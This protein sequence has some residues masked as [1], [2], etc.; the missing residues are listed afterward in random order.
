LHRNILS[1]ASHSAQLRVN[2]GKTVINRT[3]K[4]EEDFVMKKMLKVLSLVL[5]FSLFAAMALTGCGQAAAPAET[6]AAATTAAVAETTAA[7]E[8]APPGPDISK[9]VKIYGYLLG[10]ALTGFPDV[11][12]ALNEKLK[13]DVNATMEINYIGWADLQAKYPLIL[14]AGENVDWIYTAAWCQMPQQAAKGAFMEMTPDIYQKY[15]PQKWA[16]IKDTT[17]LKEVSV[18]GK[19]YMIPTSTPDRKV[20]V[21]LYRE[22]LRKKYNVPEIKKMTDIEPYLEAIKKNEP[23]MMPI[24]AESTYDLGRPL[25][26]IATESLDVITDILTVTGS[27][28]GVSYKLAD[29]TGKL[30]IATS[31]P[32]IL[33]NNVKAA[34]I[35]KTWYDKGYINKNAMANKVRSKEAFVQG[36]SGIGYGNSIDVQ[37][38]LAQATASGMEVGIIP[39]LS[40][41]T[42]KSPANAFTNNGIAISAKSKNWERALMAMDLIMENEAY[43]NLVYYGVEGKH[44]VLKDGKIATPDGVTAENNPYPIDQAGF[45]F[46]NKDLFKP[47]EAWTPNY[48]QLQ[49][50]VKGMLMPDIYATLTLSTDSIKTEVANCNQVI[51]QYQNPINLGAVKDVDA[52]YKTLDTKLK[53][54]GVEK[55][56][57]ELTTQTQAFLATQK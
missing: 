30:Y 10:A 33:A 35:V 40:G 56:L 9:E 50:D 52:A 28:C 39:I 2:T 41:Q 54:A 53:A 26:D 57:T 14:A 48:T 32:E 16:K 51:Q 23:G 4:K 29:P 21:A 38:N 5:V 8:T 42:G 49:E 7:A 31:D 15:M 12:A 34:K 22:D 46:V 36:K 17:A 37:G 18:N 19:M 20:P 13:K 27:G 3:N 25:S 1:K 44:Y 6:T 11:M 45:W 43:D 55:I 47:L 24:N